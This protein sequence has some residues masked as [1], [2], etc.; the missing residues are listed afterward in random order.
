MDSRCDGVMTERKVELGKV[1]VNVNKIKLT[2]SKLQENP[3]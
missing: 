1:N 3:P 2:F